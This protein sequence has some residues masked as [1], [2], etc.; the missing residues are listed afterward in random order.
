LHS[1]Y[2]AVGQVHE[3]WPELDA[4]DLGV[5][6]AEWRDANG[7][8]VARLSR[9]PAFSLRSDQRCISPVGRGVARNKLSQPENAPACSSAAEFNSQSTAGKG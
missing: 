8:L 2:V 6:R 4:V 7:E 3:L 9:L 1:N 5:V